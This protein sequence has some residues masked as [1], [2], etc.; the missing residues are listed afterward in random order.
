M[1]RQ[2]YLHCVLEAGWLCPFCCTGHSI[3]AIFSKRLYYKSVSERGGPTNVTQLSSLF[4]LT[5]DGSHVFGEG[6]AAGSLFVIALL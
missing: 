5:G 3:W 4:V 6:S 1:S 2:D